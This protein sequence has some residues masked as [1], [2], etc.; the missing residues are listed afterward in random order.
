[1]QKF[2]Q[3]HKKKFLVL[4]GLKEETFAEETFAEE[5]FAEETFAE[6]TFV[7]RKN[8]EI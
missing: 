4:K 1:M 6:E 5:T 2:K 3:M 7:S 8:R